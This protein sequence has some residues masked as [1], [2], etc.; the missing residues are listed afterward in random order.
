[1][2]HVYIEPDVDKT[3]SVYNL[4]TINIDDNGNESTEIIP[5]PTLEQAQEAAERKHTAM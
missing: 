2:M 4:I 1:M 5:Y 3:K